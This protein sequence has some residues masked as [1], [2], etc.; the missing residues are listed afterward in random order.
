MAQSQ[1]HTMT[2][3]R[4]QNAAKAQMETAKNGE[5]FLASLAREDDED[6]ARSGYR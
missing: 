2:R 4:A 6:A 5:G 1:P 3:K